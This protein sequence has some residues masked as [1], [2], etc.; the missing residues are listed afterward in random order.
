MLAGA[1]TLIAMPVLASA[2][3]Q[4]YDMNPAGPWDIDYSKDSCNLLRTFEDADG[5]ELTL[6]L[7]RFGPH[8]SFTATI[9]GEPASSSSILVDTAM[10]F[11]PGGQPN[12]RRQSFTGH[13]AIA[14][15]NVPI[16][17]FGSVK[18]QGSNEVAGDPNARRIDPPPAEIA[19]MTSVSIT[20]NNPERH[21]VLHT[22]SLG[23][24][25]EAVDK[26][27]AELVT[28]W[29]LDPTVQS[30]L[31]PPAPKGNP[32]SWVTVS[33]YPIAALRQGQSGLVHF[34]L[35]IDAAGSISDCLVQDVVPPEY[36]S[37]ITCAAL[38]KRAHFKPAVDA[39]GTPHASYWLNTVR[40]VAFP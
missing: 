7:E 21:V 15:K 35:M 14:G 30:S 25:I 27:T 33:D 18:L 34:R 13:Q 10:Q 5:R 8:E 16:V 31:K 22:G 37:K 24:V 3:A 26:C 40:Y 12:I 17:I 6:R 39:N 11:I 1:F 9:I 20:L 23:S 36:F 29:G 28:H 4:T 2:K 19:A 32:G 38:K